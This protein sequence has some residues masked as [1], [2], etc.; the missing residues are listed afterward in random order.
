[1]TGYLRM[2]RPGFAALLLLTAVAGAATARG[3]QPAPD[4]TTQSVRRVLE[5]LPYYGVFDFMAF[6]VNRGTVTLVGYS[7]QGSLKEDA[8]AAAKRA[9]GVDEVDN[10]IELLPPSPGDDR[11][12]WA[13]FYRIYTDDFLSRYA[14][15]GAPGAWAGPEGRAALPGHAADRPL[16]DPHHRQERP[17]DAPRRGGQRRGSPGRR[18]PRP[19]EQR[20]LRRREQPDGGSVTALARDKDPDRP[21]ATITFDD[22][23]RLA[24]GDQVLELSYPGT[25]H[26]PGNIFI[27]ARKQKTLM[28]DVVFPG[29]MPWRRLALAQDVQAVFDQVW[30]I[31]AW[32]FDTFV[33]G[34]VG[35]TGTHADVATQ[36]AFME[37]LKGAAQGALA[38]TTP[39]EG[40]DAAD[41]A[42]RGP[43]STTTSI[44]SP[45]IASTG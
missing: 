17:D 32:E 33:G 9:S 23:Y 41:R 20:R 18:D 19:R 1:M 16:S 28:V 29:W 34:H 25:G 7:Y 21:L 30:A 5:R 14:P 35:R 4:E 36:L 3:W 2:L 45:S 38:S 40:L 15:G 12:R 24:V 44:A 13:T 10:R 37:D 22:H 6:S 11:I 42:N 43:A 26:A 27:Y 39:G 8:A 31:D